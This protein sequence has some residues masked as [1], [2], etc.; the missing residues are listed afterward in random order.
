LVKDKSRR[1]IGFEKLDYSVADAETLRV[2]SA[3]RLRGIYA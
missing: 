2:A 1:A 3:T